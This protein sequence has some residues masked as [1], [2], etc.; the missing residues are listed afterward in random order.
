MIIL[1]KKNEKDLRDIPDEILKQIKLVTVENMDQVLEAALRRK[2]V[3]LSAEP[4]KTG[5]GVKESEP[6]SE[7]ET[8]VR[9]HFP[10]PVDQPPAMARDEIARESV[11]HP[12]IR[13]YPTLMEY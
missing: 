11:D 9:R 6:E 12:A 3:P 7:T 4:P 10:P 1:P 2:P 5:A 13:E 8:P